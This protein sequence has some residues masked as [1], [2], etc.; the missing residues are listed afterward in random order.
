[1]VFLQTISVTSCMTIFIAVGKFPSNNSLHR[2]L[3]ARI[4]CSLLVIDTIVG[5]NAASQEV[6]FVMCFNSTVGS[7]V[8]H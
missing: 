1:M 3:V 5:E 7:V 2:I 4:C 8:Y 6:D